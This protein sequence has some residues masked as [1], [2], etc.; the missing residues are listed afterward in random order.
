MSKNTKELLLDAELAAQNG[1]YETA[2]DL[3][4]SVLA[5]EPENL[6]AL[7]RSGAICVQ[8]KRFE[9][10]LD[11]FRRALA[12]DPENGDNYFNLGNAFFFNKDQAHAF[13]CFVEAD[14]R[15]CSPDV[16]IQLSYQMMILCALRQ[17]L[18]AALIYVQRVEDL[19]GS[20]RI[21]MMPDFI[22]KKLQ[23]YMM[24]QDYDMA[25]KCAA[26]LAAVAPATFKN[27]AI[28]FS[29]QMAKRLY[30]AAETTLSRAER[31][32]EM[33]D[34]EEVALASMKASLYL[35]LAEQDPEGS[36]DYYQQAFDAMAP[37]EDRIDMSDEAFRSVL[38]T[39][40]DLYCKT[41]R[42]Q[43]GIDRIEEVLGMREANAEI[44]DPE[45]AGS[46][47]DL[48]NTEYT[49]DADE[50]EDELRESLEEFEGMDVLE[51][52]DQ[53]DVEYDED[54]M[55]IL[56]PRVVVISDDE[57]G[58]AEDGETPEDEQEFEIRPT[59]ERLD[60]ATRDKLLFTLTTCYL[61]VEDYTKA[62]EVAGDLKHSET[63]L[64][65]YHGV[66]VEALSARQRKLK[67]V[68]VDRLYAEAIAYF[69]KQIVKNH[70][71]SLAAVYRARLYA[72]QGKFEQAA[73]I[74]RMLSEE[75][76]EN[77]QQYIK[78]LRG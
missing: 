55:P 37:V 72:E 17:D 69:R 30:G 31:Y 34:S 39:M 77:I 75:E 29:L 38:V 16:A 45:T 60:V 10:A 6:H 43:M 25:R 13:E 71:D 21:S 24:A 62:Y 12:V 9:L 78:Q 44:P 66:Y 42:F 4:Q 54:D 40:C 64:F 36:E 76:Q 28:L 1:R 50:M 19:D 65:A 27:Y 23:L 5:L 74:S 57:D 22:E 73:Q 11:M 33:T 8:L 32:A 35:N 61:A 47:T 3:Y 14:R 41:G 20:G 2:L 15:G 18:N 56:I 58:T 26:Q 70:T 7:S 63:Q 46:Y 67:P 52:M 68:L 51:L 48:D 59:A 53:A 49:M